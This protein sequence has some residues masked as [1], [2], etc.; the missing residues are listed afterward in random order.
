[1]VTEIGKK[2]RKLRIDS[3]ERILDMAK[4]L[5]KS[6]SFICAVE[7]GRKSPPSGFE[8]LI[9]KKYG[10]TEAQKEEL[11]HAGDRARK[12]FVIRPQRPM[13]ND[14]VGLFAR[15]MKNLTE[16]EHSRIQKILKGEIENE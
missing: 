4:R 10:L 11:E 1:M 16:D 3:E 7:L 6:P 12:D 9:A 5:G 14:T 8:E 13:E 15:R 2:L